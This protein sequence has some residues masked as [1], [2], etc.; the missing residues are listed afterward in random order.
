MNGGCV[1]RSPESEIVKCE[2]LEISNER[3]FQWMGFNWMCAE[4]VGVGFEG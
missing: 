1:A 3:T 2:R 4:E